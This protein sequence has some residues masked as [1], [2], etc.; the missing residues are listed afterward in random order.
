MDTLKCRLI[1]VSADQPQS[2]KGIKIN[3][4][5]NKDITVISHYK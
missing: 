3:N 5:N 1:T 2:E 4:N